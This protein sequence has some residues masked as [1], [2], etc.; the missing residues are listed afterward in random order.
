MLT[1][2][3]SIEDGVLKKYYGDESRVIIP[4]GIT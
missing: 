1:D 2:D 3:F 4:D